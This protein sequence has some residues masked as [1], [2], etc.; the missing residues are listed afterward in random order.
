M[1][2]IAATNKPWEID[3]AFIRPGRFG[4][5][6]YVGLPDSSAR[7]YLIE[8]RLVKLK[9][10]GI[11]NV[12]DDIDISAIV[13]KTNGFNGSDMTNLLDRVEELSA[14]RS[15]ES[16]EKCLNNADFMKALG[17]ITTSVQREDI[18]KLLQWKEEN[19][20]GVQS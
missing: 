1:F 13:D 4:I 18:E 12:E 5:R 8:R 11:V 17:Q 9:E 7:H 2:L 15:I 14:L 6:V 3:S 19:D 20:Q 16:G 10:R